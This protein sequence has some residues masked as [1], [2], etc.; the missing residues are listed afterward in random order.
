[1]ALLIWDDF[2]DPGSGAAAGGGRR[3]CCHLGEPQNSRCILLV[4]TGVGLA[5]V[6]GLPPVELAPELVL[7]MVLPPV[8]YVSAVAM[9]WPEVRLNLGPISLLAVG[10][11]LFTT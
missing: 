5:L 7:L 9:S 11:V 4:L 3:G 1:M 10:C 6:P 2:Y 8:V